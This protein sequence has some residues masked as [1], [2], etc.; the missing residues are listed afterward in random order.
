MPVSENE[1]N[2]RGTGHTL[3]SH[4]LG[5]PS[6]TEVTCRILGHPSSCCIQPEA[7]CLGVQLRTLGSLKTS[8]CPLTPIFNMGPNLR[9]GDEGQH[10]MHQHFLPL[11]PTKTE[12]SPQT[13]LPTSSNLLAL[14]QHT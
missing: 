13:L 4:D 7:T 11:V 9:D 2:Q 1:N 14:A 8:D 10:I 5:V 6:L 3:N 12:I